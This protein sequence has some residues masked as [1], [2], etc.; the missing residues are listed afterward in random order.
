MQEEDKTPA[1]KQAK[2]AWFGGAMLI[3][4][5][6][7]PFHA[8]DVLGVAMLRVLHPD[9]HIERTRDKATI[10]AADF[11]VDVGGVH[12]PGTG[13][14]DHHQRGRAGKRPS[15]IL[16]S[17]A[18]LIWARY[19]GDI[20]AR[21]LSTYGIASEVIAATQDEV[22]ARVDAALVASVCATD[23]GQETYTPVQGVRPYTL[24]S[25]LD[26]FNPSWVSQPD[27]GAF[28]SA[29]HSARKVAGEILRREIVGVFALVHARSLN[30]L[31]GETGQK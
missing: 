6:N 24:S 19:G 7:G 2:K 17:A 23:N 12:D 9:A 15:G 8:D 1:R 29:F 11:V 21:V 20:V 27:A 18:G 30:T 3:V 4:T 13:R 25:V 14:F 16:Y 26:A 10:R 31:E 28:E 22:A 5:H